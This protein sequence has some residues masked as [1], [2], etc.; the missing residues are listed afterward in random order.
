MAKIK[1]G[2]PHPNRKGL[3]M[4]KNGRYVAKST[5]AKQVRATQSSTSKPARQNVT[6]Q[7]ALPPAGQSGGSKP[8]RGTR[9]PGTTRPTVSRRGAAAAK[10]RA[11]AAGSGSST[12]RTPA[13][14]PVTT[15]SKAA[16]DSVRK[17]VSKNAPKV[18]RV[19]GGLAKGAGRLIAGR[20][21]GSGSAL[22]AAMV[23]N[24]AINTVKEGNKKPKTKPSQSTKSGMT[25]AQLKAAQAK[26]NADR[27]AGKLSNIPAPKASST[28][29]TTTKPKVKKGSGV[30]GVGPV[31]SGRSYSVAKTG[32]SVTQQNVDSLKKMG[33]KSERFKKLAAEAKKK[34]L[35]QGKKNR[36]R[37]KVRRGGR[38]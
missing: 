20:D 32:K 28:P 15:Y 10:A 26:A 5:Y 3:V 21:D 30:S 1:P 9:Q 16:R 25:P 14:K 12:V 6:G 33:T 18:G 4:G 23:A 27:R 37:N 24:D 11:A 13:E 35:E 7:R 36:E 22:M 2:T 19:L 8:P 38:R 17:F 34:S 29:K 31:K